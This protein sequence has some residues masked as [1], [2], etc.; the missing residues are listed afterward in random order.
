M[1]ELVEAD[2][3]R[4]LPWPPFREVMGTNFF[5]GL[6]CVARYLSQLDTADR[7]EPTEALAARGDEAQGEAG[8]GE[9]GDGQTCGLREADACLARPAGLSDRS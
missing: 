2:R 6:R 5:G 7:Q 3:L 4:K 1:L 9:G 8:E